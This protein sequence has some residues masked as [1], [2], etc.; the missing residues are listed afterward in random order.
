VPHVGI[1]GFAPGHGQ[2]HSPQRQETDHLVIDEKAHRVVRRQ[3]RQHLRIGRDVVDANGGQRNEPHAQD[4]AEELPDARGAMV[5]HEEQADQNA[6]GDRQ[7]ERLEARRG[8]LQALDGGQHRDGRRD[9]TVTIEQ[10]RPEHAKDDDDGPLAWP[11]LGAFQHARQEGHHTTFAMVVGA[12]HDDD[13]LE[14]ND[15]QQRPDDQ[16]QNAQDVRL[17]H[18][19]RVVHRIEGFLERIKRA[20]ADV[21]KNHPQG[22]NGHRPQAR[23]FRMCAAHALTP[24]LAA[25][26]RAKAA[27]NGKP[28][29]ARAG[30]LFLL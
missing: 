13:V 28:A 24:V 18:R 7:H 27:P 23:R 16:R 15:D 14:G 30:F 4:R 25:S 8:D 20:G 2:E 26:V 6:Q 21:A 10:G 19:Q 3:R 12:Q 5:L 22:G 1:Q 17:D 29:L 11:L 9:D